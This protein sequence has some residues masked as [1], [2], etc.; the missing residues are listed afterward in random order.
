MIL[1]GGGHQSAEPSV[2]IE[3]RTQTASANTG[4]NEMWSMQQTSCFM[5]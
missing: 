4:R 5:T 1:R 2:T 3:R